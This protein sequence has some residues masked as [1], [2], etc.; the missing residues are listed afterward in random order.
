[1]LMI[2][3]KFI[4]SDLLLLADSVSLL[5]KSWFITAGKWVG[6]VNKC[7]KHRND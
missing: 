7:R 5:V 2:N 6:R 4:Y 1:M 3:S